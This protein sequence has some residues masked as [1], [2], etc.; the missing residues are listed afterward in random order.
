MLFALCCS[1]EAQQPKKIPV[2]GVFL[3]E[4]ES[5]ATSN[6]EAFLQGLRE[7]GYVVG[8]NI[9]LE[10]R[11]AGG[12]RGR[13]PPRLYVACSLRF[14]CAARR[15]SNQEKF[16][17]WAISTRAVLRLPQGFLFCRP[18]IERRKTCRFAGRA[19][20]EI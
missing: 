6:N 1:V 17:V 12:K 13:F 9:F 2:I 11:Y 14:V 3:P 10:Y 19:A 4:T 15:L 8:Q 5:V 18:D 7:L 16:T 20:D